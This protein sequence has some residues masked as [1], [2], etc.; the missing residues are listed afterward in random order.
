[1]NRQALH[2]L[3]PPTLAARLLEARA[4]LEFWSLLPAAGMLRRQPRGDGR[5][6][7]VLPGFTADDRSTAPLRG[8]LSWL[9]YDAR[10][11]G[12][13]RNRGDPERDAERLLARL[14]GDGPPVTLVGWSLGGVVARLVAS[15]APERVREVVTLG[16]PVEGGPKY[17]STASL[18]ARARGVDLD[19]FERHVHEVNARGVPVPLTIVYSRSDGVVGW[20]AA[21]DRYNPGARHVEVR[22]SHLG[23]GVSPTVWRILARILAGLEP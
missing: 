20:R 9:G 8:Y 13:G 1:M 16:T 5:P 6:L 3:R 14:G 23:L 10:P 2:D 7:V 4:P 18:Y 12:L 15:G 17:T 19:A 21:L 11:W 22:G